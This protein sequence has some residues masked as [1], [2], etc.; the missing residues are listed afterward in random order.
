MMARRWLILLG[1]LLALLGGSARADN[2]TVAASNVTFPTVSSI[3]SSDVFTSATLTVTCNWTDFLGGL[4]TPNVTV[5]LNLGAGSGNSSTTTTTTRQIANGSLLANYNLYT[6]TTYAAT[7]VWGGWAGTNTSGQPITFQMT[8]SG[9]LGSLSN[10]ITVYGKLTADATLAAN[11]IGPDNVTLVSNFGAG[12][13]VMQYQFSL[14]GV[15]GCAI[16]QT[17]AIPFQV[18]A[19]IIN[20]CNISIGNLAFPTSTLLT[21][22]VNSSS[23]MSVR[24]SNNTM[25]RVLMGTGLNGASVLARQMKK[26]NGTETVS[27]QLYDNSPGTVW[28]DG[29]N[30]TVVV[31]GT[32][33]GL[34][35]TRP[36]YGR[37]PPQTT[38]SPGDYKD[39]ITATVQF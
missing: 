21:S 30:G 38:P 8:K 4:L 9:G 15:L 18:S 1:V 2:C 36:V 6:D 14:L 10:V 22:T 27:Y 32:G 31:S 5:C 26:I 24:C 25:W 3:S 19:P 29:N 35:V 13:A 17:V 16:P 11:L 39:T 33:T 37:V 23:S 7:K 20:D 34:T 12:S 28:G